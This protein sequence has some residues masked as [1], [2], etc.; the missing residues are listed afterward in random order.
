MVPLY[1]LAQPYPIFPKKS[2]PHHPRYDSLSVHPYAHPKHIK[3]L[4]HFI[5]IQYGCEMQ[6]VGVPSLSHGSTVSF[7]STLLPHFSKKSP[8]TCTGVTVRLEPTAY[9]GAKYFIYIQDGCG[10]QSTGAETLHIHMI[11]M[12]DEVCGGSQP[13]PWHHN[14][15]GTLSHPNFSKIHP[16]HLD[17]M[18]NSVR[19]HPYAHPQHIK[20]IKHFVYIHYGCGMQSTGVPSLNHDLFGLHLTPI[21]QH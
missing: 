13:Q 8:P 6:S 18:C 17:M 15:V 10:T 11:W 9:E 12:W 4:K 20:V 5:Y 1:H 16:H 2:P 3:V 7:G 19:V 14:V 21:L